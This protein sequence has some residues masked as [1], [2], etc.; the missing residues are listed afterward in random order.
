MRESWDNY[1]YDI[2]KAVATRSTCP[3][4]RV[5]ALIVRD[6]RI[7]ATG[8]NGSLSGQ[9]HCDDI[10]CNIV[11]GHCIRTIHAE[12][13]A[14]AQAAKYGIP[15]DGATIYTTVT[16]CDTCQKT[17]RSAGIVGFHWEKKYP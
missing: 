17:C 7:L 11:S 1:F 8:Y 13:N 4:Q 5:G 12:V 14:L 10:G 6:K 3:R 16:P 2:A 9:E 15:I